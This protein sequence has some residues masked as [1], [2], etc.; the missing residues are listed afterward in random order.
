MNRAGSGDRLH[1]ANLRD[2]LL[3]AAFNA[4]F[5]RHGAGRASHARAVEAD[6]HH[7]VARH[8]DEFEVTA[9]TLN[10]GA[11][12]VENAIDSINNTG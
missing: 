6:S 11:E 12:G 1:L 9:V 3:E 2:V 5:E 10:A 7:A 4:D 8:F